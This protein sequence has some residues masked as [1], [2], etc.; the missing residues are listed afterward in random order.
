VVDNTVN[1]SATGSYTVSYDIVDS[2][3]N[4]ALQVVRTVNIVDTTV[5]IISLIGAPVI[6]VFKNQIYNDQ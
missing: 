1:T 3:D 4:S 2:S 6:T 5:P